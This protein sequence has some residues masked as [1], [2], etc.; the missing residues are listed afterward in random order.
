[1]FIII[2]FSCIGSQSYI[3][4]NHNTRDTKTIINYESLNKKGIWHTQTKKDCLFVKYWSTFAYYRNKII[5]ISF[6]T[7]SLVVLCF[8]LHFKTVTSTRVVFCWLFT[9][10]T[11]TFDFNKLDHFFFLSRV[12]N[13]NSKYLYHILLIYY[14]I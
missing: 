8:L 10:L 2:V 6:M 12:L 3:L 7:L 13:L 5:S 4:L 9:Q 11:I 1:M 14:Y